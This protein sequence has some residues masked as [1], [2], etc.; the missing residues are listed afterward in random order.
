MRYLVA[1]TTKNQSPVFRT[2]PP[3]A[4]KLFQQHELISR[5]S[6]EKDALVGLRP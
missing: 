5:T 3:K 6:L 4:A 1:G 2:P